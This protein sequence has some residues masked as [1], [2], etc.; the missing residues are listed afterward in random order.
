MSP[1]PRQASGEIPGAD[2]A[3]PM[4][5]IAGELPEAVIPHERAVARVPHVLY[6]ATL[7]CSSLS[8]QRFSQT[9]S[10]FMSELAN[11]IFAAFDPDPL[12]ASKGEIPLYVDL[13]SVRGDGSIA[14]TLSDNICNSNGPACLAITGHRGSGKSTELAR[15][16]AKLEKMQGKN[17]GYFV[18]QV[19]ADDELDRNDVDFP[20]VLVAIIR[21]LAI[22]LRDRL[23]IEL[24]PG[25]FTKLWSGFTDL[26][27]M[28]VDFS[29]IELEA[30]M[31]KLGATLKYSS[32]NRREIRKALN[33]AADSWLRAANDI[34]G[35]ALIHL[36]KSGHSGLV[37]MVDDLDKMIVREHESGKCLT[38][39]FLFVH[40]AAHL[41]A[42]HCHVLYTLP[43]ELAYSHNEA[44]L[45]R[46]YGGEIPV[47]PMAKLRTP[48][49]DPQPWEAGIALFREIIRLRLERA[50]ATEADLFASDAI[51]DELIR[52]TGGQPSEL[53]TLVRSAMAGSELP[54]SQQAVHRA[55]NAI[56]RSYD[57]FLRTEHWPILYAVRETGRLPRTNETE[58][59]IRQLLESRAVLLYQNAT[60]WYATNPAL[61]DL[62]PPPELKKPSAPAT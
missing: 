21:Q 2:A 40:R 11:S 28:E 38:T 14:A 12:K 36:K 44:A 56:K 15:L 16:R 62:K 19:Q 59:L 51:R 5:R 42:L 50:G 39:E 29:T 48:L 20:E 26:A 58:P 10:Y 49:P 37:I 57:R 35:Q 22:Q 52:F 3:D 61:D 34:I 6:F 41:T 43:I 33:G 18:V 7:R 8:A 30:G 54:L 9:S 32:E 31:T 27:G 47:V 24:K 25:L 46:D 53:M 60:G 1:R 17:A 4:N 23:Q 55:F 45:R 13:D